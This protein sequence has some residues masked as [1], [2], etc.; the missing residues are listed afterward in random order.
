[1]SYGLFLI[2]IVFGLTLAAHGGQKLFG[3]FGGGG[4]RG[5]AGFFEKM[6][7]RQPLAMAVLAGLAEFGGGALFA[8]GFLTPLAALALTAVMLTAIATVHWSKGFWVTGGGYEYN[9]TILSAAVA[10]AATGPGRF[11]LDNAFGWTGGLSGVWWG[12]GVAAAAAIATMLNL[13]VGR[14][15]SLHAGPAA[16]SR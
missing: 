14:T 4:P 13:T 11:S 9:L 7:F 6:G 3:W 1:M 5:T 2:R 15:H 16:T 12:A 8:A 10:I